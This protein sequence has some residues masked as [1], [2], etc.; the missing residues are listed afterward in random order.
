MF[1]HFSWL[2]NK[3][4]KKS[5]FQHWPVSAVEAK[6]YILLRLN[7]AIFILFFGLVANVS[8]PVHVQPGALC[9]KKRL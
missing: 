7:R 2:K 3:Q 9:L 6:M 5:D 4:T 8:S 1:A